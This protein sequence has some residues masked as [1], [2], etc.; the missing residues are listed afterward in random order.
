M[1][2]T[3]ST[4][5]PFSVYDDEYTEEVTKGPLKRP[6]KTGTA[7][8]AKKASETVQKKPIEIPSRLS[9]SKR[10]RED[11]SRHKP[12][13]GEDTDRRPGYVCVCTICS[14][15]RAIEDAPEKLRSEIMVR[16]LKKKRTDD[17]FS[18]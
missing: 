13:C 5:G 3:F 4:T 18:V 9:G 15:C 14:G 17:P 11:G 12:Y 2:H 16:L 7:Q 8:K 10:D 1:A 6:T